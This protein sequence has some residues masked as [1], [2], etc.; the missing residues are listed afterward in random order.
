LQSGSPKRRAPKLDGELGK[1]RNVDPKLG[2]A[3]KT[4][5]VRNLPRIDRKNGLTTGSANELV[6]I[7][8][9]VKKIS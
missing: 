4:A 1:S 5:G 3:R 6:I 2:P 9:P 7:E 8:S